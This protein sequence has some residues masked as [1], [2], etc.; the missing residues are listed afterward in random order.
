M[1]FT[2]N[3]FFRFLFVGTVNTFSAYIIYL[4]LYLF[5]SYS[6]AYSIAYVLGIIINYFTNTFWVF[7]TK[8]SLKKFLSYPLI[9]LIQYGVSITLLRVLVGK[10]NFNAQL[11]PLLIIL[12][13][14]PLTYVLTRTLLTGKNNLARGYQ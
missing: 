14:I 6:L 9:Y 12:V 13:S 11:A 10:L 2:E 3:T 8:L 5:L 7:K 1:K 4:G